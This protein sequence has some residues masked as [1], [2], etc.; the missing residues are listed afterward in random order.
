LRLWSLSRW[1]FLVVLRSDVYI[2]GSFCQGRLCTDDCCLFWGGGS[3]RV[4]VSVDKVRPAR[5]NSLLA[6]CCF[7]VLRGEGGG[8]FLRYFSTRVFSEGALLLNLYVPLDWL[9]EFLCMR[10]Y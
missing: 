10:V 8:V 3:S 7:V 2:A 9:L 5:G 1:S 6:F 4:S